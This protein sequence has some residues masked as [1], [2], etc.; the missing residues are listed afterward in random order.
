MFNLLLIFWE[1]GSRNDVVIVEKFSN[2]SMK[3]HFFYVFAF[4][5]R[6]NYQYNVVT[7]VSSMTFSIFETSQPRIVLS[8]FFNFCQISGSSCYKSFLIK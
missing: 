4:V 1:L 2:G 6:P 8:M 7:K 5:T 3:N